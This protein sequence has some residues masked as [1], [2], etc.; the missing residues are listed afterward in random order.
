MRKESEKERLF[1]DLA[2]KLPSITEEQK[3]CAFE[4]LF[5]PLAVYKMRKRE[6]KCPWCG[7]VAVWDKPFI[8]SFI[9]VDEYDCYYCG[10]SMPIKHYKDTD[11]VYKDRGMYNIITTF[12]GYQVVRTFEA[13]RYNR[14]DGS[15][16]EYR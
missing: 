16:T 15:P 4:A 2:G 12:R 5:S 8:E 1:L 13:W 10:K 6:V 3:R 14:E 9:D 11:A 7:G